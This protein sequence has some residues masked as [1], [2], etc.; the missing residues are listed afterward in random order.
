M[1]LY[2]HGAQFIE[3][4]SRAHDLAKSKF[5][6]QELPFQVSQRYTA[7]VLQILQPHEHYL[8]GP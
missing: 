1:P 6:G 5:G 7:S 4:I 2:G 3:V 8:K